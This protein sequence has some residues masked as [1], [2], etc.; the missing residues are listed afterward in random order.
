MG[1]GR[2]VTLSC[3]LPQ[4]R[5]GDKKGTLHTDDEV[6]RH[7]ALARAHAESL[8]LSAVHFMSDSLGARTTFTQALE[9]K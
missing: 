6:I 3:H 4:V 2:A 8:G 9:G 7:A 5:H 1:C